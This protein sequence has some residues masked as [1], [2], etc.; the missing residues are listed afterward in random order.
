V[1]PADNS[2][3]VYTLS[4]W[5]NATQNN[6]THIEKKCSKL[7]GFPAVCICNRS[8]LPSEFFGNKLPRATSLCESK[9]TSVG[10]NLLATEQL[11]SDA[12]TD[13]V[14]IVEGEARH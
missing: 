7:G 10:D 2:K 6:G 14:H 1:I 13:E 3:N 8:R 12:E 11:A 9:E 5:K 4:L